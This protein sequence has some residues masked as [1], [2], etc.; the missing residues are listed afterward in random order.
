MFVMFV[1]KVG[2][3][4]VFHASIYRMELDVKEKYSLHSLVM[5]DSKFLFDQIGLLDEWNHFWS[6]IPGQM[7]RRDRT[8][9]N[10]KIKSFID[11]KNLDSRGGLLLVERLNSYMQE[12]GDIGKLERHLSKTYNQY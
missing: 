12:G 3:L 8:P 5:R 9:D 2:I 6:G 4:V 1:L 10:V 7:F 11:M